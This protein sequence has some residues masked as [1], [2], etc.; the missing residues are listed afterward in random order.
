M[1]NTRHINDGAK[2]YLN[3]LGLGSIATAVY[4][5]QKVGFE[6]KDIHIFEQN[7]EKDLV[8]GSCDASTKII[9]GKPVYFMRGSR[10]YEDKVYCCT[11]ELWS[12]I[13]YN[14]HES[15]LDDHE[16]NREECKV[17]TVVRLLHAN[18]EKDSGHNLGLGARESME[19]AR[20]MATPESLIPDDAKI[21]DYFSDTFFETNY[22]YMWRALFAF[23]PW[24][25]AVEMRRYMRLFFHRMS[26]MEKMTSLERTRYTNYHS[27]VLPALR[28]L[29]DKGVNIHYNT[30]ITDVDFTGNEDQ[31]WIKR[32]HIENREGV[33]LSPVEVQAQDRVF[34]TIGSIVSNH[35]FGSHHEP[36]S[37]SQ[38]GP[39]GGAYLLWQKIS[40]K[41]TGLGRPE[42]F[43]RDVSLSKMMHFTVTFRGNLFERKFQWLVERQMGRQSPLPLTQ[44]PW[45]MHVHT[46]RQP[47]FPAQATDSC[48][49]WV[50][51]LGDH[52]S[53]EFIKK[54][55][56]E[57]T[58]R[59]ILEELLGHL[60][61]DIDEDEKV[62]ILDT[63]H[64][65]PCRLPYGI[66][67]FLPRAQG[68][69]P[70]VVPKGSQN[71]ALLG[72]FVEIPD[73]IVFTTE[74]SVRGA[75][76]AIKELVDSSISPPPMYFGQHDP[77]T[78]LATAKA[79]IR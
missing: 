54:P 41:Q 53:G 4:L 46:Y 61:P 17:D 25:S 31:R 30:R 45:I 75:I 67:Q 44:S 33:V 59:E 76:I 2:I 12:L 42:R 36:V 9:D 57:C 40:S 47:F 24:H 16:R 50:S 72:Q 66:S 63:S 51:A 69:R 56:H 52:H 73:G 39:L 78:S 71:F 10:M 1:N 58:G 3:G 14:D 37:M 15:C 6:P 70:P 60:W 23:Q 21:T 34:L 13:P 28:L 26:D 29:D 49:I 43:M 32:L 55:M 74:Y 18:G 7:P 19:M 11:K 64:C 68:D 38:K 27:L 79:V 77:W 48:V 65:I 20:L 35:S 62:E 22:W 8:G 5:V